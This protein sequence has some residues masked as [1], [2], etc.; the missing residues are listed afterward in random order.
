MCCNNGHI[1]STNIVRGFKTIQES[2]KRKKT[3][4]DPT[5]ITAWNYNELKNEKDEK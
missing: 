5:Y 3:E 4:W 2:E 1:G